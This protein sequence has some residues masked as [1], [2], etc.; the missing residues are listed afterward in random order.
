MSIT[1][2][3][4]K[5][6]LHSDEFNKLVKKRRTVSITATIVM[7]VVYFGFILLIAFNKPFLAQK[8]G[9]HITLG[10]LI[11]IGIIS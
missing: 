10:L 2:N 7:L 5:Q 11:G 3:D 9:E 6:I 8:I 1:K 4:V